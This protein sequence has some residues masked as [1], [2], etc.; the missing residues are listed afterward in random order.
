MLKENFVNEIQVYN[1][2]NTHTLFNF[3]KNL[4]KTNLKE[5]LKLINEIN[6]QRHSTAWKASSA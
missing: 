6:R 3:R 2:L 5:H 1:C 4:N